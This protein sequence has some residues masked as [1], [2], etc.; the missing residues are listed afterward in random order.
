MLQANQPRPVTLN[1]VF[2]QEMLSLN[3]ATHLAPV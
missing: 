1:I 3:K 2:I